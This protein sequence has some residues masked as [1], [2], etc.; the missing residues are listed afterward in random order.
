M[1]GE[2][3]PVG[4]R[5]SGPN[6]WTR[7]PRRYNTGAHMKLNEVGRMVNEW[8]HN[9]PEHFNSVSLDAFQI[10]PDHI[11][12]IIIINGRRMYGPDNL[13]PSL[14]KIIAYYKY[15]STK[16]INTIWPREPRPYNS[17]DDIWAREP[18]PYN[19]DDVRAGFP[20][21]SPIKK[22]WQR[23][24]YEHIIRNENDLIRIREYIKQ[25]PQ[26]WEKDRNKM[27]GS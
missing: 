11:H 27:P 1:F 19:S 20:S 13:A 17:D 23:N 18:R 26:A 7:E 22:I 14:G 10:M 6:H 15:Q 8:W 5:S 3:V 25:N 4:A 16:Y 12:G 2:I 24:Y 9:I 21:P